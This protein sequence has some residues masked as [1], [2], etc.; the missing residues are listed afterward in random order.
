M[1]NNYPFF[2]FFS[3]KTNQELN[4][5]TP[6]YLLIFVLLSI[7][8]PHSVN[9][10]AIGLL[11]FSTFFFFKKQNFKIDYTLLFPILLYLLMLLSYFW[12][13]DKSLTLP[14]LS[15][16]LP[17]LLIPLC[18]IIFGGISKY[19]KQLILQVYSYG[20]LVYALFYLVKAT[21]RY[22]SSHDSSV[23]FYH[24]LV[25]KDVNAIHV[26]VYMAISFFYFYTKPIK[27]IID[28]LCIGILL[29]MVILLS[30]QNII[31][32]FIGLI[33]VYH[34]FYSKLSKQLRLK[35]LIVF[36]ILVLSLGFIGS[37][38]DKLHHEYET[39]MTDSTVNDVISKENK[40]TFYNVSIK[41]AWTNTVFNQN[42]FFPGTAFRVYQFRIFL[43]MMNED[44]I[45]WKGYGLN[46][47]YPKIEAKGVAYHVYQGDDSSDGYQKM[48]FHNQYVQN[49][50]DLG[51]FG[52]LLIVIMLFINVKNAI[53]TKDFVN[54][55]FAFLMIS[56]FLT[57]SFLW[58]QRGVVFFTMMYCLFNSGINQKNPSVE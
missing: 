5:E 13:I 53:K 26:S 24:E 21:I 33:I 35:N 54:F 45:F 25:T 22:F 50:A 28:F 11:V 10:I 57:E 15:K 36:L 46:A 37:I 58:R 51:V 41:Q 44:N 38:K 3:L 56:L 31:I 39:I 29:L 48:N 27:K 47:S 9:S 55:A 2:K 43:E 49:F 4:K 16:E 32:A 14:A 7:P 34:L 19:Q 23:F 8:L 6:L 42:D 52:F 12:T 20:I 18:F 1:K 30:S 40:T 17:F